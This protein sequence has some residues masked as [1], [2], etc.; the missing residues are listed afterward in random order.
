AYKEVQAQV[1]SAIQECKAPA[2]AGR[3]EP[4]PSRSPAVRPMHA[5]RPQ[6][7]MSRSADATRGEAPHGVLWVS[8]CGQ[9]M[10]KVYATERRGFAASRFATRYGLS[11]VGHIFV[12]DER[13]LR[14]LKRD[15]ETLWFE[16]DPPSPKKS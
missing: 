9:A 6:T 4:A 8:R 14:A 10:R 2:P 15:T 11:G 1:T 13:I 5:H 16:I 7:P 3:V 12:E